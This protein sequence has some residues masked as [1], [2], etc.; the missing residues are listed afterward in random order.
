MLSE[1]VRRN[2]DEII[3]RCRT[4]AAERTAHHPTRPELEHGIPLFLQALE[5][6]LA[7]EPG[8]SPLAGAT[9]AAGRHGRDLLRGG[10][11]IAHVVY[12]YGDACQAITELAI[13]RNAPIRTEEFRALNKFLDDAI[14]EAVTE[15]AHQH[16]LDAVAEG[17]RRSHE[18]LSSFAHGLHNLLGSAVLAFDAIRSGSVGVRGRT[19]DV[20]ER[21]LVGLRDLVDRSLTEVRLTAGIPRREHIA[22]ARFVDDVEIS[23]VL[24]AHARSVRLTVTDVDPKLYVEADRQILASIISSL[25]QNAFKYTR[26]HSHVWLRTHA[27]ADRVLFEIEDQCGG[28]PGGMSE[29]LSES[30]HQQHEGRA[31]LAGGLAIC[32][33]GVTAL[34]GAIRVH[35]QNTGCVFT[36]DLPRSQA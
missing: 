21:T 5:H 17:A 18:H 4:R 31:G 32:V 22:V 30:Y 15:Y 26:P 1:F 20:L 2:R 36:V 13:E 8:P 29:H 12:D 6:A 35:N 28:V 34:H 33:R 27:T 24:S 7:N 19:G 11:S 23:A 9:T 10:F 25:L 3:A 16:E 14:A